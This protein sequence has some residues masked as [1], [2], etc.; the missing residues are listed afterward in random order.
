M[1]KDKFKVTSVAARTEQ[2]SHE[3]KQKTDGVL[4][5]PYTEN[6]YKNAVMPG[7]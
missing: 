5:P 1:I 2:L 3:K 6:I 4:Y 7:A